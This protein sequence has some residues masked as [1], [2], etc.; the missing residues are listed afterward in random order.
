MSEI[1]EIV[2]TIGRT[3]LRAAREQSNEWDYVGYTFQT[4]NG[5]SFSAGGFLFL[6]GERHEFSIRTFGKNLGKLHLRQREIMRVEG[7]KAWT[8]SRSA[9]RHSDLSF[10]Q[11][12]EFDNPQRWHSSP[13]TAD[14]QFALFVG[15][16]FDK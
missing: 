15:G 4:E 5:E 3:L 2:Q 7:D 9:L 16:L 6:N 10:K 8:A 13:A 11:E 14:R 12:F 1:D